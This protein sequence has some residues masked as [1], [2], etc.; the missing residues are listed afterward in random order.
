M[1]PVQAEPAHS[2]TLEEEAPVASWIRPLAKADMLPT[3]KGGSLTFD[4]I[5]NGM[6]SCV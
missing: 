4:P 6:F 5:V 2:A 1:G 3:C